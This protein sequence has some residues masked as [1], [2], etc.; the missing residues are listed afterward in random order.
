MRLSI[1]DGVGETS[2]RIE[3]ELTD[4]DGLVQEPPEGTKLQVS[5]GYD[6]SLRNFGT[7]VVDQVTVSGYPQSIQIAAQSMDAKSAQKERRTKAFAQKEFPTHQ[8]IFA[9]VSGDIGLT[10]KMD[11]VIGAKKNVFEG[12]TEESGLA[13]LTRIGKSLDASVTVK[14]GNLVVVRKGEGQSVS[15]IALPV[16]L[17][18]PGINLI[19]YNV[20]IAGKPKYGS[21]KATWFDRG[22][23]E[24]KFVVKP[25]AVDGPEFVLREPYQSEDDAERAAEA[26]VKELSRAEGSATFEVAGDP[27]IRAEAF[28]H[29]QG[30]KRSA[31]GLWRVTEVTHEFSS[32]GPY[33]TSLRCEPPTGGPKDS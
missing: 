10:L 8:D 7:F 5:G 9:K 4:Q 13:F 6:G 12:Q 21:V 14:E 17:V 11:P 2:D 26:K 33:T 15:G 23:V 3:L 1:T 18:A 20:T 19:S 22:K 32:S 31:D 16:L 30:V 25:S 29:V 24:H 27:M 28:V